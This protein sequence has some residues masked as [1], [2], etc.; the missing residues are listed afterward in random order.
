MA[1]QLN[2]HCFYGKVIPRKHKQFY[3]NS[4]N[5]AYDIEQLMVLYQ[6]VIDSLVYQLAKTTPLA[7]RKSCAWEAF[8]EAV[9][10]YTASQG[11][12]ESYLAKR[13]HAA[14]VRHNKFFTSAYRNRSM[15][16]PLTKDEGNSF[17]LYDVIPDASSGGIDII[18]EKIM[19]DQFV[20]SLPPEEK[21]L[22]QMICSGFRMTQIVEELGMGEETVQAMGQ[23]IGRKRIAFYKTE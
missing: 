7:E 21:K 9:Q 14:L 4:Q 13:V 15:E 10:S 16:A 18:E 23:A 19:E 3:D 5:S 6:P 12:M 22:Y 2:E 17:C 20:E 1:N 8:F 11:D